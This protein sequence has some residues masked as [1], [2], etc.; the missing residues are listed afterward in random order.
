MTLFLTAGLCCALGGDALF[1]GECADNGAGSGFTGCRT[2]Q[3]VGGTRPCGLYHQ[4]GRYS[5]ICRRSLRGSF[6]EDAR[7][8][9]GQFL[10]PKAVKPVDAPYFRWFVYYYLAGAG[11]PRKGNLYCISPFVHRLSSPH[12]L[13]QR[14]RKPG[15]GKASEET[16]PLF[17]VPLVYPGARLLRPFPSVLTGAGDSLTS[18]PCAPPGIPPSLLERR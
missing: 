16:T 2:R 7:R 8:V 1:Y 15:H 6:P 13:R 3:D 5:R 17:R 11:A 9:T 18:M 14:K 10:P 4:R 12:A